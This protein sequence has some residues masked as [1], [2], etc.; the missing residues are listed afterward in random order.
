[1][2]RFEKLKNLSINIIEW[3]FYQDQNKWKYNLTH[4]AVSK[5]ESDRVVHLL[6][7][8]N[9]FALSQKL[10]IFLGNYMKN[11]ISKRFLNSFTIEITLLNH[12]EK[13][14]ED[15]ICTIKTTNESH[16]HWKNFF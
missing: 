14:G 4:L 13:C 7:N 1:M 2:H 16:L 10:H 15:D 6:M 9:H 3:Y 8:K 5:N 12:K 11:F